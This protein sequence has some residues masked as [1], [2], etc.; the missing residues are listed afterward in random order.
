MATIDLSNYE[1]ALVCP[2]C[3]EDAF[4]FEDKPVEGEVARAEGV[5]QGDG[6]IAVNGQKI[7]CWNC[8]HHFT[9]GTPDDDVNGS[10]HTGNIR[11]L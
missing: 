1:A 3:G 11:E 6:E 9:P 5:I 2:D 4:Y 10:L 8:G 7:E